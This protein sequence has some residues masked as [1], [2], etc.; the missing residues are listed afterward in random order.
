MMTEE[1]DIDQNSQRVFAYSQPI[2]I[3]TFREP[4]IAKNIHMRNDIPLLLFNDTHQVTVALKDTDL[5]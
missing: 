1:I 3:Y 4:A 2:S 5:L